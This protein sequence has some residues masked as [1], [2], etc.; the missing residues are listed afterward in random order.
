MSKTY[1][2]GHINPDTDTIAAAT[3]YAW[4]LNERDD[5]AVLAARAGTLN[6]QTAWVLKHLGLDAP[7]LLNDASPRFE[8]LVRRLDTTDPDAPLRE[9]WAIASRTGGVAPVVDADGKPFGLITGGSIF[10]Y[11]GEVVGAHS[12][13]QEMKISDLLD[14]PCRE[15]CNMDV[16]QLKASGR[17]R[18]SISRL[19]RYEGDH[20][21]VVNENGVYKGVCRQRD[22]LNPPRLKIIMVDHNEARQALAHLEEAEL[23]EILDHHRLGNPSTHVPIR[24]TVDIVGSTSTL[25]SE[26]IEE[27]GLSAPPRIAGLLLAG[28]LSDTLIL[29]SPTTT[30]RDKAAAKRL[31]RWAFVHGGPLE[32]ETVQS[33]GEQILSAG[34]GLSSRTPEEIVST[35]MKLYE[36]GNYR[37]AVA[38]A[39][40][41]DLQQLAKYL[42]KLKI[43]LEDLRAKK[44]VDF[45][46]LMVTD[47]VRGSSRL[48]IVEAP[49][50]LSDL[51]YPRQPDGTR[52]AKGV[53]SRKKQLLPGVLG[54]LER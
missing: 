27:A 22:A 25:V 23:I 21:F 17:I 20:F 12:K 1:V 32:G 13:K 34:A 44:A 28:L 50:E 14:A 19:L 7:I 16:P 51:P 33:Y 45:A 18:D 37:F 6:M 39:E 38:Q 31:G 49:S 52:L 46:M 15:A 8:T 26:K 53:V 36:G 10:A 5:S 48:L 24:F 40:V 41:T 35:D 47:V 9:A 29:T 3:G 42:K 54:L 43:A 2:I 30:E 11:M 4:L